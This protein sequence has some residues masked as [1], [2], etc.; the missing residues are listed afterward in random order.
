MTGVTSS[1]MITTVLGRAAATSNPPTRPVVDM[2]C[3]AWIG[4]ASSTL[5]RFTGYRMHLVSESDQQQRNSSSESAFVKSHLCMLFCSCSNRYSKWQ[6][7]NT[8]SLAGTLHARPIVN[9]G[10]QSSGTAGI[11]THHSNHEER[12]LWT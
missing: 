2:A 7:V 4:V 11:H 3:G 6:T 12:R 9:S 8:L 5:S 10:M 1:S